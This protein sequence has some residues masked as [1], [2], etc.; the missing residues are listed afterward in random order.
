MNSRSLRR[1]DRLA[2]AALTKTGEERA[3]IVKTVLKILD[4]CSDADYDT[5][6]TGALREKLFAA[7][8]EF[9]EESPDGPF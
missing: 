7:G 6:C 8:I 3:L 2:D 5:A 1:L 4:E 9:D